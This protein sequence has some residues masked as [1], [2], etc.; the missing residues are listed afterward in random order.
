MTLTLAQPV[1]ILRIFDEA[2]AREFYVGFLGFAIAWDHRYG[3]N[4]PLYLEI[5]RGGCVIHLS[6]H[7]GDCTPV[8]ALR[9]AVSD[10]KALHAELT[11][12][13]YRYAKPGYDAQEQEFCVTDPFGNRLIFHSAD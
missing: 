10:P 9:I 12:K 7:H 3:D 8:S 2:K 1:P 11:A 5:A 6:E 13:D 4:F